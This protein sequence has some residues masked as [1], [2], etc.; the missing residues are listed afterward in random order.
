AD[1][2]VLELLDGALPL[3]VSLVVDGLMED[4]D[5]LVLLLFVFLPWFGPAERSSLSSSSS[6]C[7]FLWFLTVSVTSVNF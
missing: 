3:E 6:S 2:P 1:L 7:Y 5:S 4:Y